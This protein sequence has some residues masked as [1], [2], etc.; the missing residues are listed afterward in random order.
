MFRLWYIFCYEIAGSLL[1]ATKLLWSWFNTSIWIG[2]PGILLS[3]LLYLHVSD[4]QLNTVFATWIY[5]KTLKLS[6]FYFLHTVC[7]FFCGK[8][9][10]PRTI[11][12]YCY[13][14]MLTYD[15]FFIVLWGLLCYAYSL[16]WMLLTQDYWWLLQFFMC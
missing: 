13:N 9:I 12:Q 11:V 6:I 14:I 8:K 16:W 4:I 15:F 10:P 5:F 3:G 7:V 1:A 2:I